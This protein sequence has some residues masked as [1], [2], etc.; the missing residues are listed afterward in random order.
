[1]K[2]LPSGLQSCRAR[3]LIYRLVLLDPFRGPNLKLNEYVA[4]NLQISSPSL[5]V[6][7]AHKEA[8]TQIFFLAK[9]NKKVYE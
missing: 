1:M 9:V 3:A 4:S 7:P 6:K 8:K 5:D 2:S